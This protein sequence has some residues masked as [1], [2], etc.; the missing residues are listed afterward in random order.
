MNVTK[1]E[2]D[3]FHKSYGFHINPALSGDQKYEVLQLLYRY[4]SMFAR[5]VT[6]I[7]QCKGP[8]LTL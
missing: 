2:L 4:K 8:P 3:Q 6:D 7:K 1:T 5:D